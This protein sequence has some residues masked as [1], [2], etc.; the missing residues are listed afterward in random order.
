[1][2]YM[3]QALGLVNMTLRGAKI[4]TIVPRAVDV[5]MAV[6]EVSEEKDASYEE[7]AKGYE[8]DGRLG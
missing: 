5:L 2:E 1:M 7:S 3:F 6:T 4:L 8:V